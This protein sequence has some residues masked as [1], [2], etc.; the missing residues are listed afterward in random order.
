M[1]L[2]QLNLFNGGLAIVQEVRTSVLYN[3]EGMLPEGDLQLDLSLNLSTSKPFCSA[4]G[5]TSHQ[6]PGS[7]LRSWSRGVRHNEP[8]LFFLYLFINEKPPPPSGSLLLLRE[9][10]V[11]GGWLKL[12]TQLPSSSSS[13]EYEMASDVGK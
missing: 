1:Q 2:I 7:C 6:G 11:G 13:L 9:A 5:S 12:I 8:L 10:P 4:N 3:A